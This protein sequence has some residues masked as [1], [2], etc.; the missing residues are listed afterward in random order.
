MGT[1]TGFGWGAVIGKAGAAC[2]V[3]QRDIVPLFLG[4]VRLVLDQRRGLIRA[5]KQLSEE[6]PAAGALWY[7]HGSTVVIPT[8]ICP[9]ENNPSGRWV[10]PAKCMAVKKGILSKLTS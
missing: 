7:R 1:L 4:G 6:A 2:S 5:L 10:Q 3:A 8:E 9:E